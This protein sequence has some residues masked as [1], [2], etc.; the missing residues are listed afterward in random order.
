[1]SQNINIENRICEI[2][3]EYVKK[4]ELACDEYHGHSILRHCY[5]GDEKDILILKLCQVVRVLL[6]RQREAKKE[7]SNELCPTLEF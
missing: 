4:I 5:K 3:G 7:L 2:E 6:N 1:M